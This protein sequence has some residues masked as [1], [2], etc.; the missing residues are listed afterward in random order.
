MANKKKK[1]IVVWRLGTDERPV[2]DKDIKD[3]KKNLKKAIKKGRDIITPYAV[4][5]QVIDLD[6]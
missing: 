6:D 3:F 2:S 1:T 5:I 4:H